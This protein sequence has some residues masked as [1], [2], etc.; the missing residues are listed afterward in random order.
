[1][2]HGNYN[3]CMSWKKHNNTSKTVEKSVKSW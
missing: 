2:V 1:M 3:E